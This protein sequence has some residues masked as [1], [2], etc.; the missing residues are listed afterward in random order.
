MDRACS[1][2]LIGVRVERDLLEQFDRLEP[3]ADLGCDLGD[4]MERPGGEE[5]L[6]LHER[7]DAL[8]RQ[9]LDDRVIGVGER[10]EHLRL[11]PR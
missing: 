3:P 5:T 8:L 2:E 10:A 7:V 11:L 9:A 4:L 1:L 6:E